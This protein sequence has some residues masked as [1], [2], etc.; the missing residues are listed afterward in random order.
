MK[1]RHAIFDMDGTLLDS[2]AIWTNL[3]STMLRKLG[4]DPGED[5]DARMRSMSLYQA[6]VFCREEFHLPQTVDEICEEVNHTVGHFYRHEA[7]A[8]PGVLAFVRRL[9][10][11]GVNLYVA[12]ATNQSLARPALERTGLLACF[13]GILTCS[14][15]HCGKDS[16]LIYETALERLGGD[17]TDTVVFEDSLH[18]IE[19]AK[20]AGF[21]V[22]AVADE[23]SRADE[24]RIRA[25]ADYWMSAY[26]GW[27]P[28]D[29]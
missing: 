23:A 21:R 19:T 29:F 5:L 2:T 27:K 22:A 3:G 12:T 16:P 7:Q 18:A 28:E 26:D 6:A 8:K 25:L 20:T 14:E 15:I 1:L 17:K 4:V 13:A 24:P 10:E 9:R 11:A